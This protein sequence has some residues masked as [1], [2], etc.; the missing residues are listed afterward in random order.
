MIKTS[1]SITTMSFER[2][3]RQDWLRDIS[4]FYEEL[5][6]GNVS[7]SV[8]LR[9]DGNRDVAKIKPI[10]ITSLACLIEAMANPNR[11]IRLHHIDDPIG[12]FFWTNLKFREYW[13]GG[14][15]YVDAQEQNIFNLWRLRNEE[16]EVVPIRIHDYLKK[17][18]FQHKD[19]SSVK[20][21]LDEAYYNVFDHAKANGNAFSYI[22]Y[23]ENREM[24][25]VSVCD[26]GE[27]IPT[28]VR[29]FKPDVGPD[30]D[31]LRLAMQEK[32][33]VKSQEHNSGMGLG[34]IMSSGKEGDSLWIIS[35]N[36]RL[37]AQNNDMRCYKNGFYFPG[38]ALFY[39]LSLS[40]FEEEE[41]IDNFELD[42]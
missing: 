25:F 32:F 2:T 39:N 1:G 18:Y 28:T 41:I 42:W 37:V 22:Q 5:Q 16:K 14:Q 9:F 33:T 30:E 4:G 8:V 36:A 10:H 38:T 35:N 15:N 7:S 31:A 24:L 20:N 21:S 26:F 6:K 3:D 19:L 23:D 40:K 11:E 13:A 27:G 12:D 29:A 34:N 17:H